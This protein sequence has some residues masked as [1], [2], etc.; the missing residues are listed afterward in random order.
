[1]PLQPAVDALDDEE[2]LSG[3][4]QP[5]PARFARELRVARGRRDEP[6]QVLVLP[7]QRQ[8]LRGSRLDRVPGV[9]LGSSRLVVQHRDEAERTNGNPAEET[10]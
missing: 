2:P 7:A 5:E 8:D 10:P 1:V 9:Q 6:L 4:D 3:L